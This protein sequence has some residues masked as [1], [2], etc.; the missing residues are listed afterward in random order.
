MEVQPAKK[1][2][3]R[4]P[5]SRNRAPLDKDVSLLTPPGKGLN[6]RADYKH[7]DIETIIARQLSM[8]DWAQQALRNEM[9]RA[10]Q[11]KGVSIQMSD[12]DKLEKL[13][14]AIVR[15]VDGLRKSSDLAEEI[16]RR[17]TPE[18]L[19]DAALSKIEAQDIKTLRYA[20]KRLRAYVECL[21]PVK[22]QDK[23]E[24]AETPET[25]HAAIT[26]LEDE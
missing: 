14:N 13:S 26:S 17:L 7:A 22:F 21:G 15:A 1:R 3:G 18:Q 8:L 16:A 23:Q 11:A 6:P 2:R 25:A 9:M 4:P 24:M 10:Y 19:L 5:G 20:I 12:I